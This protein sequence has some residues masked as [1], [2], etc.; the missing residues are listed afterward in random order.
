MDCIG[1]SL[2]GCFGYYLLHK[3]RETTL[4][5]GKGLNFADDFAASH[6]AG[7]NAD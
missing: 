2:V 3:R 5:L 1:S 6:S 4:A 7:A